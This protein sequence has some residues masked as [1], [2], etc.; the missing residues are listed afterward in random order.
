MA[1]LIMTTGRGNYDLPRSKLARPVVPGSAPRW[2]HRR[3][4]NPKYSIIFEKWFLNSISRDNLQ[5]P[6]WRGL[7]GEHVSEILLEKALKV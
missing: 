2:R 6:F 1:T 7:Q 4:R 5:N 3:K